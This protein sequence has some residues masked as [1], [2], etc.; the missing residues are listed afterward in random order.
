MPADTALQLRSTPSQ[1]SCSGLGGSLGHIVFQ[2]ITNWIGC[3]LQAHHD[4]ITSIGT[5][6]TCSASCQVAEDKKEDTRH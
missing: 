3:S 6:L 4:F 1:T 2:L 5:C